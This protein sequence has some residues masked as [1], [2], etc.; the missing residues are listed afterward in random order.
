MTD[1]QEADHAAEAEAPDYV[2]EI[3]VY[4]PMTGLPGHAYRQALKR[5]GA[6]RDETATTPRPADRRRPG[7]ARVEG[8][9]DA[10]E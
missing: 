10:V 1:Q 5:R 8:A 6:A 7:R 4:L 9:D 3:D 2:D